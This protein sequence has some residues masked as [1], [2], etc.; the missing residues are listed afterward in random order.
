MHTHHRKP[1][2]IAAN[3]PK[4][5]QVALAGTAAKAKFE[6]ALARHVPRL[7]LAKQ[8]DPKQVPDPAHT[9]FDRKAIV[10][11]DSAI[12]AYIENNFKL[13]EQDKARGISS[14]DHSKYA[15]HDGCL[16]MNIELTKRIQDH[17]LD[18]GTPPAVNIND[19]RKTLEE[20]G[21]GGPVRTFKFGIN[22]ETKK[23]DRFAGTSFGEWLVARHEC[24]PDGIYA[25]S[26]SFLGGYHTITVFYEKTGKGSDFYIIDQGT[27]SRDGFMYCD[28]KVFDTRII[29]AIEAWKTLTYPEYVPKKEIKVSQILNF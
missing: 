9:P 5:N 26:C 28:M 27:L 3:A 29:Q 10:D 8:G 12:Y 22:P 2:P 25:Y 7:A 11:K 4:R 14:S 17:C 20:N 19:V 13:Y 21:L 1:A 23:Y 18:L 16:E 24:D 6:E 15:T